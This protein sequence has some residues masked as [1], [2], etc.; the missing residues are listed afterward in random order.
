[1]ELQLAGSHRTV[2][3]AAYLVVAAV[4]RRIVAAGL[5]VAGSVVGVAGVPRMLAAAL[6]A[7]GSVSA[8]GVVGDA[9][10]RAIV[11]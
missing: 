8:A 1:M 4:V 9:G 5:P 11:D 2:A 6:L 3:R 7:A 10:R